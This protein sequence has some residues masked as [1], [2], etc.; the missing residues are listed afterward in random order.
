[1]WQPWAT[2]AVAGIRPYEFRSFLMPTAFIGAR[3]VV[4]AS[5]RP[6]RFREC[7]ELSERLRGGTGALAQVFDATRALP[8]LDAWLRDAEAVFP[9]GAGVGTV[10]FGEPRRA[11][12]IF[13]ED[14]E[15]I[16]ERLWGWPIL[17]AAR[18]DTPIPMKGHVQMF[19]PWP[20]EESDICL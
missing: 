10:V 9:V 17:E 14:T 6:V 16:G 7:H 1:M 5:Q 11:C 12:D 13:P 18:W 8:L 4:H 3:V 15:A 20:K 19:W 2:L